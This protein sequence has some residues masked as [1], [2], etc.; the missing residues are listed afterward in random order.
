L[1]SDASPVG[2]PPRIDFDTARRGAFD[3][4]GSFFFSFSEDD[5]LST[6]AVR[7]DF[8]STLRGRFVDTLG[9]CAVFLTIFTSPTS[10]NFFGARSYG[11][12]TTKSPS[13]ICASELF[14]GSISFAGF[15]SFFK[16][17]HVGHAYRSASKA[18]GASRF[19]QS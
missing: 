2:L 1:A 16:F 6:R 11:R 15:G 5:D 17:L 9:R 12:I 10:S 8:P 4:N 13:I 7:L 14:G 3:N 18:S 19:S